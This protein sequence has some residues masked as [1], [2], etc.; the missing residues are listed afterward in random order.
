MAK[1]QLPTFLFTFKAFKINGI[2]STV[3][4][5]LYYLKKTRI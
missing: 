3:S 1:L 2:L 4:V 5:V